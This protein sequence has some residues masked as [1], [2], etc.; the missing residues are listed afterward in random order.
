MH[1][2]TT[3][4]TVKKCK[5]KCVFCDYIIE[6][7]SISLKNGFTLRTNCDFECSSRNLIYIAI[8]YG[9][10]EYYVGETGDK[11]K[12]RFTVHRQQAKLSATLQAVGADQHFRVCGNN[13]YGVF[14]FYRPRSNSSIRRKV[15][16]KSWI[17][18]LRPKLNSIK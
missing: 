11:L 2:N 5:K 15:Y 1:K 16:E 3:K 13:E 18:R 4:Y 7:Q 14:P 9:Y 8:C 12:S 6:G 10:N 17:R